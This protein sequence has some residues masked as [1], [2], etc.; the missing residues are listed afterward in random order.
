MAVRKPPGVAVPDPLHEDP[1]EDRY[2][3][4][5]LNGGVASG[6]V[7]PWALLGLARH[8]R[9]RSIG[10]NSVGALAAALAAAAEYGR[11]QNHAAAFE[12]LRQAPLDFAEEKC[13]HRELRTG[14]LRLFQPAAGLDPW[15]EMLLIALRAIYEKPGAGWR[16]GAL[17][18]LA[19]RALRGDLVVAALAAA[20]VLRAGRSPCSGRLLVAVGLVSVISVILLV[21]AALIHA[22]PHMAW[23][24]VGAGLVLGLTYGVSVWRTWRRGLNALR[25]NHWGL[26]SGRSRNGEE[27]L[28]E[29]LHRGIQL[30]AGRGEHDPPLTF[31]DLWHARAGVAPPAQGERPI[32]PAIELQMFSTLVSLGRPVR[33]PLLDGGPRLFFDPRLWRRLFPKRLLD[34]VLAASR[35]YEQASDSDPPPHSGSLRQQALKRR[36][37]EIPAGDLPIAVAARLS[38]SFPLL[39][40]CVPV[41]AID[42][43]QQDRELRELRR[44]W[45]TDGGLCTNF[46]IHLFD[47]AHP[48]WPT[49]GLML[50][51]RIGPFEDQALWLPECHREGRADNWDRGVPDAPPPAGD[52]KGPRGLL[53]LLLGMALTTMNW[54]DALTS[55]L[56]HVRNRVLRMALR[57][58]E[59]QLNLVM[60]RQRILAMAHRYGS[61]GAELILDR[62]GRAGDPPTPAWQEHVY[63]RAMNELLGLREHLRGYA[64]AAGSRAQGATLDEQL[65]AAAH[66][67]P[68]RPKQDRKGVERP[69]PAG[70]QLEARQA[71]ALREAVQAVAALERE[72]ARRE[73]DFGPYRPEPTPELG[74]RAPL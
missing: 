23:L 72:L 31:S 59:G 2:C 45:M 7:Y 64:A 61:C 9:F 27:A 65:Q 35:P 11:C 6:V 55:R 16:L 70:E 22:P 24:I 38:M 17:A 18:R 25:R 48:R 4:L 74:L 14:M 53:G 30:S 8:Y 19:G 41:Y 10:G 12:P 52:E 50:S 58:D 62:Y 43:E 56:P 71:A 13:S 69:D 26:C 32:E 44:A 60:P 54:S 37:R 36:L 3:D 20:A 29:W 51:R 28:L 49:F 57:D 33:W 34:A 47:A 46:P 5:V 42:Y 66:R 1:P 15:F 73:A 21:A 39:F 40:S 63:V 67:R 68:L